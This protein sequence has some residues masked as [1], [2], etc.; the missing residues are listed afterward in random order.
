MP[1]RLPLALFALLGPAMLCRAQWPRAASP[2]LPRTAD[3]KVNMTAPTPRAADG[4]PDFSGVWE[5]Y[6]DN[7]M[8]KLLLNL[9]ADLK[10][11]DVQMLPDA[12][13][14]FDQRVATNSRD[15]PGARCLPSGIPEKDM[16]PAPYKI[17]QI[18]GLIVVLYESRTIFRQIFTDGRPLPADPNPA[19]QG[20]STG[21]W[22]GDTLVVETAGFNDRTWLDMQGHPAT[23]A[24]H[25][26]ER[27]TR[28]DLGH[29]DLIVTIN[30]PK[31]YAKPWT[32]AAKIH[33]LP[34]DE[35][36]EHICEENNKDP[37]HL[38]GK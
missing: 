10:P 13:K 18:P 12:R 31:S 6:S 25:V 19:W 1:K 22:D 20:Y 5:M 38:V 37:E 21:H 11:G 34:Q 28:R 16:V 8:P 24:L 27:F 29:M 7:D 33:L 26:T 23:E 35:L 9:A 36:I 32:I 4:H 14:V 17:I 15:H 30:D 3:G 2:T